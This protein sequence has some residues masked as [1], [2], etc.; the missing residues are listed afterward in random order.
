MDKYEMS[1]AANDARTF[2]AIETSEVKAL[3][4]LRGRGVS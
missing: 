4:A 3:V 2:H 1:P